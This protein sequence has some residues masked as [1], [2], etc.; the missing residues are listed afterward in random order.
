SKL[1]RHRNAA[2]QRRGNLRLFGGREL[3]GVPG[4][5]T[6]FLAV[7]NHWSGVDICQAD[8]LAVADAAVR[9]NIQ[10]KSLAT[11]GLTTSRPV[12]PLLRHCC[13]SLVVCCG[14]VAG[15]LRV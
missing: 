1:L 9:G 8:R 12:A 5:R 4:S 3:V 13:A 7:G 11:G 2:K 6:E 14:F 15:L 10:L